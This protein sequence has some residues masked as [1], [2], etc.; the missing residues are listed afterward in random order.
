MEEKNLND[1]HLY[2]LIVKSNR[3]NEK[4]IVL[5]LSYELRFN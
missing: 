3:V 1:S 4:F 2:S 5:I